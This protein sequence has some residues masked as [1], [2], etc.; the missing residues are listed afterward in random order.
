[1]RVLVQLRMP[2][3]LALHSGAEPSVALR[4]IK[5]IADEVGAQLRP[6]HP[7]S[8]DEL[9]APF[10]TL[11]VANAVDADRVVRR[12]LATEAVISSYV[13]PSIGPA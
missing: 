1:M 6:V 10:F 13:E 2:E 5:E 3:A 12:L 11:E 9:L 8:S 7:D 4:Q